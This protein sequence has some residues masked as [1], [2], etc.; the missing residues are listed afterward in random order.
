MKSFLRRSGP[1]TQTCLLLLCCSAA[2]QCA[3]GRDR[4]E[5]RAER[6]E[7]FLSILPADV[8]DAFDAIDGVED[9]PRVGYLLHAARLEH[10]EVDSKLD[11]IMTAELIPLFS[12]TEVV[13]FFWVYFDHAL[14]TG[15]VPEP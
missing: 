14:E 11:S 13:E 1:I 8:R 4:A 9:C 15:T 6:L 3:C 2:V 12:D 10:P 7:T 5:L